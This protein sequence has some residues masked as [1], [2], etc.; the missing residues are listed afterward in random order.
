LGKSDFGGVIEGVSGLPESVRDAI[1]ERAALC[2]G[3]VPAIYLVT[4]AR[5]N[6]QKPTLV[7]DAEWYRAVNDGGL[8]MDQ[9]GSEAALWGWT[10]ADVFQAPK[11]GQPGGLIW[12]MNGA[13]VEAFGPEYARLTDGR[14]IK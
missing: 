13:T 2:A 10:A 11:A 7:S 9:W 1:E 14:I 5:L 4:W 12:R 6:H 8:F 3:C